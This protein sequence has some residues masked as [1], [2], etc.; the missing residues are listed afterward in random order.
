MGNRLSI[1]VKECPFETPNGLL[2]V[3][4]NVGVGVNLVGGQK[5]LFCVGEMLL[6]LLY[7]VILGL[8]RIET[9]QLLRQNGVIQYLTGLAT[10]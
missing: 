8:E 6:A 9:T 2:I 3:T 7:P 5:Q 1:Q 10:R 4:V